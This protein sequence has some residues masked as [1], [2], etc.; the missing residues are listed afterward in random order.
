MKRMISVFLSV[1][2]VAA[3]FAGCSSGSKNDF[4]ADK[5][6]KLKI[7]TTIFPVYD[8]IREIVGENIENVDL[9]LLL[10]NGVDLHSY[11]PS[12]EDLAAIADGDIFVYVGGDSDGWT[13]DALKNESNPHR[14]A[15]NLFEALGDS[16]KPLVMTEGMEDADHAH[17]ADDDHDH[18]HEE[19]KEEHI[20]LSLPR[21]K[22]AVAAIAEELAKADPSHGKLYQSNAQEY[23][24]KLEALHEEYQKV[25]S[26]GKTDTLV[27][28]DRFP[29]FYMAD[30]YGL[31][32]YG[33]FTGCSAESEASFETVALLAEKLNELDVNHVLT[34]EKRTHKIPETVIESTKAKNQNIL[35][36]NS[37]QSVTD[38]EIAEGLT[39]LEV[40]KSNLDILKA[41]LE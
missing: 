25:A 35:A 38:K 6:G 18:H 22:A 8:W 39:Y 10:K 5:N 7:V 36:M 1:L 37:L 19:E 15:I 11:Q 17:D 4:T 16:L 32:Y 29:F 24:T 2:L 27:F 41:A 9:T 20:W 21:A 3:L 33:A 14:I 30:D 34:T 23:E 13:A 40:M 12:S 31:Q 28:A 26:Q